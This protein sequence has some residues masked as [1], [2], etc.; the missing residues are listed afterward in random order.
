MDY[1]KKHYEDGKISLRLYELINLRNHT[2]VGFLEKAAKE[3][4]TFKDK[5]KAFG[6]LTDFFLTLLNRGGW[7]N[8]NMLNNLYK[9]TIISTTRDSFY[10]TNAA[11]I[12]SL[13]QVTYDTLDKVFSR[14][15]IDAVI[16]RVLIK[17]GFL[18]YPIL[19][20]KKTKIFIRTGA[21]H[22]VS[23]F[24]PF[25]IKHDSLYNL[26]LKEGAKH[27]NLSMFNLSYRDIHTIDSLRDGTHSLNS[28]KK[29]VTIHI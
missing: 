11:Y 16:E 5:F 19:D 14:N 28:V 6:N 3:H 7:D 21:V 8:T 20:S 18:E 15:I 4:L 10:N 26:F 12:T 27:P 1:Y 22:Y 25:L 23:P 9:A 17:E 29:Q 13:S 24:N 2:N